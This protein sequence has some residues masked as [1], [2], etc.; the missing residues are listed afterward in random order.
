MT[1]SPQG[2]KRVKG[3]V[4][5]EEETSPT[6]CE[7]GASE[8]GPVWKTEVQEVSVPLEPPVKPPVIDTGEWGRVPRAHHVYPSPCVQVP[9]MDHSV[10]LPHLP[11]LPVGFV[12]VQQR[13]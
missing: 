13:E 5:E 2:C 10:R 12:S 7:G 3:V 11:T 8:G 6:S 9:Q 4:Y 1:T